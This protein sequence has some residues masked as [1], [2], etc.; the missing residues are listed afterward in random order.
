MPGLALLAG[1]IFLVFVALAALAPLI[2]RGDPNALNLADALLGPSAQ[3]PLGTD[4]LGRD[5]L[6]RLLYGGRN[7]LALAGSGTVG[8]LALG[9]LVGVPAGYY[10]GRLDLAVSALTNTLLA[11]P[12]LLLTLAILGVIGPGTGGMLLALIGGGWVGHARIFRAAVLALRE[13]PYVEA[14][15]ALGADGWRI[16]LRHLLPNLL[17]TV[18]VLGTLDFGALL[19]TVS[20][21]SF[22]G[23][24]VQPPTADWGVMLNEGR[25]F[26]G[27][28]PL[29]AFA[30]GAC[31]TV[32]AL[33][34]NL[35]G[36]TVRDLVDRR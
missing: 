9:L 10:G 17:P 4:Q 3:H 16:V 24:G 30:P 33:A 27:L 29:L 28:A 11:L 14:A 34:S 13:Q 5:Q 1:G 7:T 25:P 6:T 36:D 21:L 12:S 15:R 19:L 20:S 23:L 2:A 35:L 18:A 22:L 31:I 32:V 8:I 26:F